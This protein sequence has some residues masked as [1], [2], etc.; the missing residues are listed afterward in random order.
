MFKKRKKKFFRSVVSKFTTVCMG[1]TLLSSAI[2]PRVVNAAEKSNKIIKNI[3]VHKEKPF[4]YSPLLSP[5]DG[6][7]KVRYID[8]LV[9]NNGEKV[10]CLE[11]GITPPNGDKYQEEKKLDPGV[12]WIIKNYYTNKEFLTSDE[13]LNY[14]ITYKAI[15]VYYGQEDFMIGGK[16][17]LDPKGVLPI[18]DKLVTKAKTIKN[19]NVGNI[20]ASISISKDSDEYKFENNKFISPDY[21]INKIGNGTIG[22]IKI[23]VSNNKAKIVSGNK[24][25]TTVKEGEKFN[26]IFN[27]N[28]VK[29][30]ENIKVI[31]E[32]TASERY[33]YSISYSPTSANV[34]KVA[35]YVKGL[36]STKELKAETSETIQGVGRIKIFK[37]DAETG[38]KLAGAKFELKDKKTNK[39]LET[40]TTNN[41]G[42][43]VSK[44]YPVGKELII[45]EIE[46]PDKYILNGQEFFATITENMQT[47]TCN[48]TNKIIKG[49]IVIN[50]IDK[51]TKQPLQ[52]VG[53]NVLDDKNNV[54]ETIVTDENGNARTKDLIPGE[55][56]FVEVKGLDGYLIDNTPIK[57]SVTENKEYS[58]TIENEKLTGSMELVKIDADTN[59]PLEGVKFNVECIEGFDKGKTW[60]LVSDENGKINLNELH[61]GKYRVT[62][63]E[64]LDGYVLNSEAIDFEITEKEQLVKLE[65]TNNKLTGSMELVKIDADTNEP[66]EGVKFNVECIEGFD[67]GKTWDLVSDENGKINLNELH[68]GKYRVTETETLDGYVL[69]S[70]AIDFEITEKEQLVKLEMTNNKLTGSMELVKID[71]DTNEPLEG[72][73]FNVECIEGFDKGKTWDLVSDE[74]GKINLNELHK[75]KY[76]VTETET[77]DGYVLNSEAIDFEITENKQ[78][79]KLEM[80]NNKIV[81][82]LPSTGYKASIALATVGAIIVISGV[83]LVIKRRKK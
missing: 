3:V 68:K 77:L 14:Y 5:L 8:T 81:K 48:I 64:T 50:K 54:L 11:H 36:V 34:Q 80:T 76:R 22:D 71:A 78:L 41:D 18:I 33:D 10:F 60:D 59:E 49:A 6:F 29:N 79:V 69:N 61:K 65:M 46:A 43:G 7:T 66:L 74:N 82:E 30:N 24:E 57:V 13:N 9:D 56:S 26:I 52:G 47:I 73:K 39:L 17:A 55:Y 51:D 44:W 15:H 38:K 2:T 42:E 31:A 83:F 72:V 63:T 32:T 16:K 23:K 35:K 37:T 62:E 75:G 58:F 40:L 28:D 12:N 70:E 20:E 1:V 21:K 53:F 27:A 19:D 25:V 4:D 67:K 45:K